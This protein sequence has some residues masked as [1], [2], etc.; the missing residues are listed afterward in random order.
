LE[1]QP[2]SDPFLLGRSIMPRKAPSAAIA[3]AELTKGSVKQCLLEWP[4]EDVQRGGVVDHVHGRRDGAASVALFQGIT[5]L[6][7]ND[8]CLL[9]RQIR[10]GG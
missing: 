9:M 5:S 6:K 10:S 8:A 7:E 1:A 3:W 4:A 2:A